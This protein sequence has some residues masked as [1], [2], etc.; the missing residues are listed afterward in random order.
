MPPDK[1]NEE[2]A[3]DVEAE[4]AARLDDEATSTPA[5]RLTDIRLDFIS[6]AV[7]Y[8]VLKLH[9]YTANGFLHKAA[10][11]EFREWC[12]PLVVESLQCLCQRVMPD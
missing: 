3:R 2:G 9:N 8:V 11:L 6:V 12:A 7:P 5:D 10:A 1:D 4:E